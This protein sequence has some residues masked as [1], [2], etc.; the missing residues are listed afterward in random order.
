M[1]PEQPLNR[2]LKRTALGLV[3]LLATIGVGGGPGSAAADTKPNFVVFL[4][5]DH[6][7]RDSA[8]YGS[9]DAQTP[10]MTRLA[11]AGLTF[12]RAFV[13][14][15]SCAPSR[16]AMLTGL[17]P[18]RNGA[19]AN[20]TF[21][22]DDVA[23]LP[24]V[25]RKLG[26]ETAAFGKVAHGN[27]DV[28]RHGFDHFEADHR[29]ETVAR[30]L[31]RRDR[32]RPIC[33][34]V[35][36]HSPHVPWPENRGYEPAKLTLPATSVD[37]PETR[38]QFARYLSAVTAADSDLG[39]IY[40]LARATFEP[41]STLFIYTSDHGAQWPFGKWNLY[42]SGIRVPLIAVW[43]G[44]IAAGTRTEAMVQWTDLLPT[45]I[46]VA[47]GEVPKGLDGRSFAG[48]L[49]GT[50]SEHRMEI[51]TTH[52]GDGDKNV[53]P[54]RSLRTGEFHYILN[55]LPTHAHTSHIDRGEGSG[56]GWRYFDEW[57]AAAA[58]DPRAA[59]RVNAY[60]QRPREELYDLKADPA[61]LRNLADDPA[62]AGRLAR[63]REQ[64]KSW[65]TEQGDRQSVFQEPRLLPTPY[66]PRPKGDGASAPAKKKQ[67]AK[68][69]KNNDE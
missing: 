60:H 29:A 28:A 16:A 41:A 59:A 30:F 2:A 3:A 49:R 68:K 42:D 50:A 47:G 26:Y 54:I 4:A 34:F 1:I 7:M 64:L 11:E 17:M 36:T 65:M 25:L 52:S 22:R 33:L 20:H 69:A 19:E 14:S 27:K 39:S 18:A 57:V 31:A 56:D 21:K 37:T 58:S 55:V 23:S 63:M 8:P 12:T 5:D 40:D 35:G 62:Q 48:V 46:D 61:E 45:L 51:F 67:Q 10:N 66:P 9:R 15:P 44:V 38:I 43:P 53:Y 6:G 32:T 24:E 13:A